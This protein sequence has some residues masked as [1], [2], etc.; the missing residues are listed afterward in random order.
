MSEDSKATFE[1]TAEQYF[2]HHA[3][4]YKKKSQILY[5]H[6]FVTETN[7]NSIK[8]WKFVVIMLFLIKLLFNEVFY[9]S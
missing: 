9:Y 8:V 5:L 4:K 1:K 3:I 6:Y 7:L 2:C